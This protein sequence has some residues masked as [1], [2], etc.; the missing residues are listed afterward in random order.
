[1]DYKSKNTALTTTQ[2]HINSTHNA[3]DNI[4][5]DIWLRN[6]LIK[7]PSSIDKAIHPIT[8]TNLMHK[9]I[10]MVDKN[11]VQNCKRYLT[12]IETGLEHSSY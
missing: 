9:M 7:G 8:K 10:I 11:Q 4:D 1:M 2:K 6:N 3:S 12:Q 5:G